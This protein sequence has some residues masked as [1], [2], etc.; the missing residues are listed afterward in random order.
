MLGARRLVGA[1][2]VKTKK[3][4]PST[5]KAVLQQLSTLH[6]LPGVI[7][8]WR[9]LSR[10]QTTVI[11]QLKKIERRDRTTGRS[12][13][14]VQS[15]PFTSTG[16]VS[17]HDPNLQNL[18][19]TFPFELP[20]AVVRDVGEDALQQL[21]VLGRDARVLRLELSVRDMLCA[22]PG[23]ILAG[24]DYC[25][26]EMR[27]LAHLSQ[28]P[29]LLRALNGDIDVFAALTS[30]WL[31]LPVSAVTPDQRQST[32]AICYGIVYGMGAQRL[33]AQRGISADEASK[34]IAS[35]KRRFEHLT[36][37]IQHT[38]RECR[39]NGCVRTIAGRRRLLHAIGSKDACKVAAA[40]RKAINTTIQ[41]SAADLVKQAMIAIHREICSG[42]DA[43]AKLILQIHD[44]LLYEI[45]EA[46]ADTVISRIRHHMENVVPLMVRLPVRVLSGRAWGSLTPRTNSEPQLDELDELSEDEHG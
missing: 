34:T 8:E 10:L 1:T 21:H 3:A 23:H 36:E 27:L 14:H 2:T 29:T 26:L 39:S 28:D 43:K 17:I 32:K 40:E 35:F 16:R 18:P 42:P 6:P 30:D 33:A 13:L 25:Q 38:V 46:E 22:E 24:F 41:G 9:S 5:N 31:G 44:E 11:F 4:S 20:M 45:V 15:N 19:K 12:R 37:F 7:L